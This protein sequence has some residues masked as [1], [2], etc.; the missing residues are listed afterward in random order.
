MLAIVKNEPTTNILKAKANLVTISIS[1]WSG[2]RYDSDA[3]SKVVKD[4]AAKS[5]A[6]R[7][8]KLLVASE[9]INKVAKIAGEA[10]AEHYRITLPWLD[11]GAR[12]LPNALFMQHA[13][14]FRTFDEKYRVAA[15]EFARNYPKMMEEG[16]AR[17]GS[18]FK[19]SDYPNPEDI[20]GMFKFSKHVSPCPDA[21]DF[22][23]ELPDEIMEDIKADL[24]QRMEDALRETMKAPIQQVIDVVNHM[25]VRLGE[26]KNSTKTLQA[27]RLYDSM[28]EH[29]REVADL[30]PAFNLTGDK[31]L[32]ALGERMKTELCV[33]SV[34]AMKDK[35]GEKVRKEVK[36]SADDIL[37][38]AKMLMAG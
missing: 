17:M 13:K 11:D 33:Y 21:G 5:D 4:A 30:I 25:S 18:L 2:R 9:H 1:C 15:D 6:A 16:K 12:V 38:Q 23:S 24:N 27:S 7:V 36:R 19:Q 31:D 3:S 28:V 26:Y 8:N 10:R 37:A 34:D 20:R 22:R 32:F 29:I 35:R 14:M